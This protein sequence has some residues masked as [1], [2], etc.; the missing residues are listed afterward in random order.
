MGAQVRD[1]LLESLLQQGYTCTKTGFEQCEVIGQPRFEDPI[2]ITQQYKCTLEHQTALVD[3][4]PG[5]TKI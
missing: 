2:G 1:R 5:W 4:D 3:A